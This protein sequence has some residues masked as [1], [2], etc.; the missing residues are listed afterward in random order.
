MN[1][2]QW[3]DKEAGCH[4]AYCCFFLALL[5]LQGS[6]SC[7]VFDSHWK[8]NPGQQ[9]V[10]AM[11]VCFQT[12][13]A[14]DL[15]WTKVF[16]NVSYFYCAVQITISESLPDLNLFCICFLPAK[17]TLLVATAL[18]VFNTADFKSYVAC[19]SEVH[20]TQ[21]YASLKSSRWLSPSSSL[22]ITI[23]PGY[24]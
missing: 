3:Q 16:W 19:I 6:F 12:V 9:W 2:L 22:K 15:P 20:S 11:C 8:F 23:M 1:E 14:K 18:W 13:W 17:P 10:H 7:V 24:F 5:R 21:N 4:Q